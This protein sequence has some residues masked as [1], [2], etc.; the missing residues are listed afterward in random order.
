MT[1]SS[2][3]LMYDNALD[4]EVLL[5]TTLSG[6]VAIGTCAEMLTIPYVP[7]LIGVVIGI[8][9][10]FGFKSIKNRLERCSNN[11]DTCGV[12]YVFGIP[13]ILGG[14]C[15]VIATAL[16]FELYKTSS[17]FQLAETF[18]R[19]T[20]TTGDGHDTVAWQWRMQLAAIGVTVGISCLSGTI[21]GWIISYFT[22]PNLFD[23][24]EHFCHVQFEDTQTAHYE[25]V[26]VRVSKEANFVFSADLANKETL[27]INS[28]L[29]L[30]G[31]IWSNSNNDLEINFELSNGEKS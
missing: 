27:D 23:D 29:H 12:H 4:M 1:S 26:P 3:S 20:A 15:G 16:I 31:L 7:F 5:F 6:G 22:S 10:T 13:G 11:H 25:S 9:S 8:I 21:T 17:T 18:P 2:I 19:I 24:R 30:N 14:V 28:S